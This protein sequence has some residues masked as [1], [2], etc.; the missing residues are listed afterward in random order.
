MLHVR[1]FF[2]LSWAVQHRCNTAHGSVG[3]GVRIPRWW[4]FESICKKNKIKNGSDRT[5][6]YH[7]VDPP[8]L[9]FSAYDGNCTGGGCKNKIKKRTRP[10]F[11][12]PRCWSPE[13][14]FSA[15]YSNCT[16]GGFK[17]GRSLWEEL[18]EL[19]FM[20][21]YCCCSAPV[22]SCRDSF[23]FSSK[24]RSIS[25]S[26]KKIT[27]SGSWSKYTAN[28]R[29]LEKLLGESCPVVKMSC[30]TPPL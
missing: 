8:D 20:C 17:M 6:W 28:T 4:D 3:P 27:F 18:S 5:L 1:R 2:L 11:M 16:G 26:T 30:C 12:V 13:L 22:H 10:N 7:D 24:L 23:Q 25:N 14:A 15:Y 9:A 21:F 29:N 19:S